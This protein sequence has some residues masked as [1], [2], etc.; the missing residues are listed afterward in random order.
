MLWGARSA[1]EPL[2]DLFRPSS[3]PGL[4]SFGVTECPEVSPS[5]DSA[6]R[7]PGPYDPT[8]GSLL[9]PALQTSMLPKAPSLERRP[10]NSVL[11]PKCSSPPGAK[12]HFCCRKI[13]G[14]LS[15]GDSPPPASAGLCRS[16][17]ALAPGLALRRDP[18]AECQGEKTS[19][20]CWLFAC[21]GGRLKLWAG[22]YKFGVPNK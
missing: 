13:R 12:S 19:S 22:N 20:K 17:W 5:S 14:H 2:G 3:T 6:R 15:A 16:I 7:N 1:A 11:K 18:K 21:G 10:K 9:H 4:H 8:G